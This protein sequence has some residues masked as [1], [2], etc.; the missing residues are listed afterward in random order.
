MP[1]PGGR[2]RR[3]LFFWAE[4]I[5]TSRL[6]P[7]GAARHFPR[8]RAVETALRELREAAAVGSNLMP[9]LI[10]C[11]RA[12]VTVGEMCG[13]LTEVFGVYEETIAF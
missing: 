6:R 13:A 9:P 3:R 10:A 8:P 11:A 1:T 7:A 4:R 2:N 5:E 12:Y